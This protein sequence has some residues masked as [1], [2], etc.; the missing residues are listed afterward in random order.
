MRFAQ[1]APRDVQVEFAV[2]V[3]HPAHDKTVRRNVFLTDRTDA[4]DTGR[5]LFAERT[6]EDMH[7]FF[8][9]G[10][11]GNGAQFFTLDEPA[12][13]KGAGQFGFRA[14]RWGFLYRAHS[15]FFE[16]K[17]NNHRAQ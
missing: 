2:S 16:Q 8:F 1:G 5:A 12:V 14:N 15:F 10:V 17:E 7:N 6:P 3:P 9:S 11:I 4:P 13:T